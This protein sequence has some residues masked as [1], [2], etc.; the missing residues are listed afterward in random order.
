MMLLGIQVEKN[1]GFLH[2]PFVMMI[3]LGFVIQECLDELEL[4][5]TCGT[6]LGGG[7]ASPRPKRSLLAFLLEW[8]LE[9]VIVK[10]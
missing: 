8:V 4:V 1:E 6:V 7:L 10:F 9:W 3:C 5:V 2:F